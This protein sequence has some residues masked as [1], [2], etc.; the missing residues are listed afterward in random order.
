MSHTPTPNGPNRT[1]P[2]PPA[3]LNWRLQVARLAVAWERVWPNIWPAASVVALFL[4]A[5]FVDLLPA[6]GPWGHGLA[7]LAFLGAFSWTL[8]RGARRIVLPTDE[9]ARR[10]L[11]R[12]SADRLQAQ[13]QT[14]APANQDSHV[15]VLNVAVALDYLPREQREVVV[16]VGLEGMSYDEA[17]FVVGVP[18]GT[19]K[20]RLY[21]GR[22]AL[23][24]L[25][26][27]E[28]TDHLRRVK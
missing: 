26:H 7:L 13:S 4:A 21:R 25:R 2:R 16:M 18:V 3:G 12:D 8:W 1:G 10:R 17:A 27:G 22:E 20:S 9:D 15:E 24:A 6:L 14:A 28:G 5:A 19:I 11:E 23:Y